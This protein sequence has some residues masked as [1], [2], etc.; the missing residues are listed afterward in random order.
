M[1]SYVYPSTIH[2]QQ[3]LSQEKSPFLS[4]W[5]A[6]LKNENRHQVACPVGSYVRR[7][8]CQHQAKSNEQASGCLMCHQC[9]GCRSQLKWHPVLSGK[10][11]LLLLEKDDERNRL[12]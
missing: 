7:S 11:R 6:L 8:E 12:R 1:S 10:S 5:A 2:K 9:Y 3:T 4:P